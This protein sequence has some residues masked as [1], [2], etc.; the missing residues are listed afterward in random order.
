MRAKGPNCGP[1]RKRTQIN[2]GYHAVAC[3]A[4]FL[5]WIDWMHLRT[6]HK[7]RSD[8]QTLHYIRHA[9]CDAISITGISIEPLC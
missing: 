8:S 3:I 9:A 1:E 7:H 2:F 5:R 6:V 4:S